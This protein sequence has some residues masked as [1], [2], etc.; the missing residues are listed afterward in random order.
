MQIEAKIQKRIFLR[1]RSVHYRLTKES[2][3]IVEI[4]K[5]KKGEKYLAKG[6]RQNIWQKAK[7]LLST[8]STKI[9]EEE[10]NICCEGEEKRRRKKY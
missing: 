4:V 8:S 9:F 3:Q 1:Q 5:K 2:Q 7:G 6:K 10:T